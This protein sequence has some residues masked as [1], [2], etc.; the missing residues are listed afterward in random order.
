MSPAAIPWLGV[1]DWTTGVLGGVVGVLGGVVGLLGGV[2]GV[3]GG[4][5]GVLGGVFGVLGGVVGVLGVVNPAAIPWLGMIDWTSGVL[6]L[7]RMGV[8]VTVVLGGSY[9]V[10]TMPGS[11]VVKSGK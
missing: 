2:V 5:V 3:L 8:E 6:P 11:A 7:V 4:V 1:R 10:V 9:G